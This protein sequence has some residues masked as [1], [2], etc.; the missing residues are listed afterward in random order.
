MEEKVLLLK[1]THFIVCFHI[2]CHRL[3]KDKAEVHNFKDFVKL[4]V[5]FLCIIGFSRIPCYHCKRT[6]S[7]RD[8]VKALC[9]TPSIC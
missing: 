2:F 3:I 5:K 6:V 9:F 7:L 8:L 1:G 4:S